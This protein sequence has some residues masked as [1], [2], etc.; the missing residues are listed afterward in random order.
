MKQHR[1]TVLSLSLL[2]AFTGLGHASTALAQSS[3]EATGATETMETVVV[4]AQKRP[5]KLQEIPVAASVVGAQ[6]IENRGVS[7]FGELLS[8]IPN[9]TIDQN[10]AAQPVITIRGI[11]SSTNNIGMESGVGVVV[12]DVYLGRPSAFSTQLIDIERVEILRGSQGTLFGK[13]TTGGLINIVTSKPSHDFQAAAD[14]TLGSFNLR[15]ARGYVTGGLSDGV[16]GKLSFTTKK[17]DGWVEN[18]TAG[19]PDLMSENFTGVRGQLEGRVA[20]VGWLLSADHG[21]DSAVDNYYDIRSG[22]LAALD[23]DGSDRSVATN[24]GDTFTRTVKGASLKLDTEQGGV[25]WVSITAQRGVDWFG[26]NDQDYTDQPILVMSRKEKQTQFSQELRASGQTGKLQWLA[27]VYYFSQ[28][29]D[30]VDRMRLDEATPVLFGL[31]YIPG[32]QEAADTIVH[33]D[34]KSSAVF[35]STTYALTDALALNTGLR[36][37]SERKQMDYRQQLDQMVG[38]ISAL[39][40][41]V[42]PFHASRRD[43]LVSGDIGV[44]FKHDKNLNSYAKFTRGFKAGGFDSTQATTSDP[45]DLSFKPETVQSAELGVKSLLAGGTLRINGAVFYMDYK[46]KQE[47]FYDGV[48]Q[49]IANAAKASVKGAEIEIAA[50][51]DR[52][53]Q[54]GLSLG[55]QDATYKDYLDNT[56]HQLVDASKLT[57]ALS[58]QYETSLGN[59]WDWLLRGDLQY[60]SKSYQQ[61]DNDEVYTQPG[62]SLINL[63]TGLRSEDG[64]YAILLWVKNLTDKTYRASTYAVDAFQTIYQSVNP[65]RMVGLELRVNL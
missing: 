42:A 32:F 47:Q 28:K 38:I 31:P 55:Y 2:A 13:N 62:H 50:R 20:S 60:R 39:A 15:Q 46:N 54:F 45:G 29:Q 59:G 19:A 27:G 44:S 43:S 3:P 35:G 7:S 65:P 1:H 61:P 64:R 8:L 52:H 49:K 51:P 57:A 5:Q 6:E 41:E 34:T 9:T 14:V 16:A 30:G 56:G 11:S 40:A 63:S 33:L 53:L 22:A 21:K 4:T 25:N 24:S 26:R 10:S 17:R 12:D 58:A 23:S 48:M 37:T 18:R 36:Y